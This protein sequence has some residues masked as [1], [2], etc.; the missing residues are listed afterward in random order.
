MKKWIKNKVCRIRKQYTDAL[1]T[2]NSQKLRLK[3]KR[4]RT[5]KRTQ[6]CNVDPN[7]PKAF[8]QHT[9]SK[10]FSSSE[11]HILT[12][13]VATYTCIKFFFLRDILVSSWR[14]DYFSLNNQCNLGNVYVLK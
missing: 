6:T 13:S 12:C 10:K 1:F 11:A 7:P 9:N 4:K 14:L 8:L 3:K 2:E 5:N